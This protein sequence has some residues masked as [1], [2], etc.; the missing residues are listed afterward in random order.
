MFKIR[1]YNNISVAGLERLPREKYEVASEIQHPDA[2]ILRSHKLHGE[3]LPDTVKAIGRAGAGVNNIPV[4]ECTHRGIVVFN[5]PGANANAVKELVL[6]G[7]LLACRSICQ[8]WEYVRGL[9][10]SDEEIHREIEAS[11]KRFQGF[12]LGGKMLG[13]VGLGAIGV[14]VANKALALGMNVSGYDPYLTVERAWQLSASV[15][16]ASSLEELLAICDF[17]TLHMPLTEQTQ[18]CINAERLQRMKKGAVLLN[19]SRGE[20]VDNQ[21]VLEA[22]DTGRLHAYVTDFPAAVFRYHPKV[23]A[24]PH[25]GASTREAEENCAIMVAEQIRD[26]LENGNIR[27]SVNFPEVVLPRAPGTTRV[28]IPHANVPAMVSKISACLGEAGINIQELLNKSKGEVAYSLIDA[29]GP[30]QR[31]ILDRIKAIPGVLSARVVE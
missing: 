21:A 28:A 26:F 25:I 10:G 24:L 22:L 27:H 9:N 13:V 12:E 29:E 14:R 7:M 6:A 1:T 31:E 15:I 4:A 2:I 20:L 18:R 23:I 19:F 11:K 17:V 5:T 30:V 8:A 16:Q 3:P